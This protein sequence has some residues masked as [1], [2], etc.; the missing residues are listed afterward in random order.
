MD[1]IILTAQMIEQMTIAWM[2]HLIDEAK[3]QEEKDVIIADVEGL[4]KWIREKLKP[5]IFTGC[6]EGMIFDNIADQYDLFK[7]NKEKENE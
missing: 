6:I 7:T 5:S 2:A 3:T 1:S 4:L